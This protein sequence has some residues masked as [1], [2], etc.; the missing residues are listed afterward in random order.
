M[1][2][3]IF[4]SVFQL[5][6]I[7]WLLVAVCFALFKP[8]TINIYHGNDRGYLLASFAAFLIIELFCTLQEVRKIGSVGQDT[9][10]AHPRY[11]G[12]LAVVAIDEA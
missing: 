3:S 12:D 8:E 5:R 1:S 11:D 6:Y 2:I 10:S 7:H 4:I 9:R